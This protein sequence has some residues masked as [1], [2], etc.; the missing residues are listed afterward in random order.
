MAEEKINRRIKPYKDLTNQRFGRLTVIRYFFNSRWHCN[1]DCGSTVIVNR[2]NLMRGRTTS[3]GCYHKEVARATLTT[4]GLKRTGEYASWRAAKERC[5]NQRN[6]TFN[7][8]GGR[9]ITMCDEWRDDFP[10]FLRDMGPRPDG[11]TLERKNNNGNYE[12]SN[13][14]WASRIEQVMNRSVTVTLTHDGITLTLPQWSERTGIPLRIIKTRYYW[15]KLRPPA[16]F[17]PINTSR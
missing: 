11:Y 8:Y 1:C 3:C 15:H 7:H 10:A 17:D 16:L 12:K 13:C 4:H 9:G 5:F 2:Q 14:R 6:K